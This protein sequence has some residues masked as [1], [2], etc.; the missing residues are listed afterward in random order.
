MKLDDLTRLVD[1]YLNNAPP[2]CP[3]WEDLR[4]Y[5]EDLRGVLEQ[6]LVYIELEDEQAVGVVRR[7]NPKKSRELLADV[8]PIIPEMDPSYPTTPQAIRRCEYFAA[9]QKHDWNRTLT[10]REL[11]VSQPAVCAYIAR[12]WPERTRTRKQEDKDAVS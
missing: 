12:H 10:A 11:G 8:T 9:L 2:R 7:L 4:K 6:L 3:P 1:F 5:A